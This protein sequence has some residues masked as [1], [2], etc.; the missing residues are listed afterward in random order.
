MKWTYNLIMLQMSH[1]E[2]GLNQYNQILCLLYQPQHSC[3][4]PADINKN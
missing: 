3:H 2:E 4:T 1:L